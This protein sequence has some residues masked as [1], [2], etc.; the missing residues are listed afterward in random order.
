MAHL[1]H[2]HVSCCVKGIA[3]A[4]FDPLY[5]RQPKDA[6]RLGV[7]NP[8]NRHYAEAMDEQARRIHSVLPSILP[9]PTMDRSTA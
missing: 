3:Y 1:Q 6:S 8:L 5:L 9:C 2:L 4:D 7:S